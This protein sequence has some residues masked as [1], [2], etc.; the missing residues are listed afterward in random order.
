MI[1]RYPLLFSLL[2]CFFY[3][4]SVAEFAVAPEWAYKGRS[5]PEA[6][7]VLSPAYR[8]CSQG[9]RQSPIN[10]PADATPASNALNI[11]YASTGVVMSY[12]HGVDLL[13]S[14]SDE[15]V[16]FQGE[17]YQLQS[18]QIHTPSENE[19]DGQYFPI[20]FQFMHQDAA[21]HLLV[22]AVFGQF[23]AENPVIQEVLS[24]RGNPRM[25][26]NPQDWVPQNHAYYA[27][28]GSLT[29]P[30]CTEGVQW[31]VMKTPIILSHQQVQDLKNIAGGENAR[32]LQLLNHR[33]V[34]FSE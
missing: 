8:L 21:G 10:I 6:W 3:T 27:F 19:I 1:K 18:I 16:N 31:V 12:D 15:Y 5:G 11:E 28:M 32:P 9:M 34:S 23:G 17:L 33:T 30:P 13:F 25:I 22:L 2:C 20:E 24:H 29:T 4:T 7:W 14:K 26:F